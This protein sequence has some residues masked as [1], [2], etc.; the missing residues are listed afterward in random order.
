MG[1]EPSTFRTPVTGITHL[2][3]WEVLR[4]LLELS[5]S[6]PLIR[7]GAGTFIQTTPT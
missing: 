3:Y 2:A 1:F 5:F 6:L 4:V 7:T